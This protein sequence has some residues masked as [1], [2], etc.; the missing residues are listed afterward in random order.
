MRKYF[1]DLFLGSKS[2]AIGMWITLKHAFRKPVTVQYPYE[3][4]RI[5][6]RFRGHVELACDPA[7]GNPKCIVCMAC[8]RAC[9]SN[10]ISLDGA[11]PEGGTRKVL[12]KYTL[13]FTTCS[14]CGLCVDSCSFDAL[15]FS[16]EYNL[17][18]TRKEDYVMDLL[19]R[20]KAARPQPSA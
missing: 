15:D 8:Q 19:A 14:L 9:P 12:T 1:E 13:D 4:V 5:P 7:T 18:S 16:K 2:L 6:A 20:A 11:K 3:T 17:A 10:C